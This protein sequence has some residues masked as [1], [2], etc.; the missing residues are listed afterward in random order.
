MLKNTRVISIGI[1]VSFLA[2]MLINFLYHCQLMGDTY[3]AHQALFRDKTTAGTLYPIHVLATFMLVSISTLIFAKGYEN[4]GY[5]EGFRFGLLIAFILCSQTLV[6]YVYSPI[7]DV[8]LRIWLVGDLIQGVV[9]GLSLALAFGLKL[10][11]KAPKKSK[12]TKAK[13]SKKK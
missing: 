4:K 8:F 1:V 7:P 10:D 9:V 11:E 5:L 12:P 6:G 2:V 13:K 3:M